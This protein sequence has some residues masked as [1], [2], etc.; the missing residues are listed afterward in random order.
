MLSVGDICV[1]AQ[2]SGG[3]LKIQT[4]RL[5]P[6]A[7]NLKRDE[8][9]GAQSGGKWQEILLPKGMFICSPNGLYSP[10]QDLRT[11]GV[12]KVSQIT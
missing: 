9:S 11:P 6:G 12:S 10:V 3:T 4:R 2:S 7:R 5:Y 8:P 1:A